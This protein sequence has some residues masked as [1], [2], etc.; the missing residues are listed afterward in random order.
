[1]IFRRVLLREL[2]TTALAVVSILLAITVTTQM[3][4]LFGQAAS[5]VVATESVLAFLGFSVINYLPVLLSLTLFIAVIMTLTRNYRDSEM[6]VWFTS[7]LSLTAWIRPVLYFS[8][9]IVFAITLLS[10]V[11]SPWSVRKSEEFQ[12][13]MDSRDEVSTVAPG[14]FKESSHADRVYFVESFADAGDSVRNVF[15]QS[16]EHQKLG[17]MVAK[18]G[19]QTQMAN[20]D[21]F[22]VL[23]NGRRYEGTAGQPDYK[24]V[25]FE[26]Y[27]MRIEPYE[28]KLNGPSP[29]SLSSTA[30]LRQP[31]SSNMAE[32]VWRVG[33]PVSALLLSILAIPLSFVNPRAGRSLNLI[34]ALMV[35]MIYSNLISISQAWVAQGKLSP[36]EGLW[37]VHVGMLLLL[38]L[39]FYRRL[40]RARPRAQSVRPDRPPA[41][42][43]RHRPYCG[44]PRPDS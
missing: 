40:S 3:V 11:L 32:W 28:T 9:P 42:P 35:Y 39:L 44:L 21:R 37:G 23:L 41:G 12:R 18:R 8:V 10:L 29:K 27:S 2:T 16:M 33:L 19:F 15:M 1:M 6:T 26:R 30:L 4:R 14:V 22:L 17:V 13:Q 25:Q 20:G 31:S 24:I 38:A 5:G 7:G 34:L 43:R 36:I